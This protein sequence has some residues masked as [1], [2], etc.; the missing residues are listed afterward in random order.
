LTPCKAIEHQICLLDT[1]YIDLYLIHAP[2]GHKP[3]S[4]KFD[5]ESETDE[6]GN[7]ILDDFD[8]VEIWRELENAVDL[9]LVKH[10][11]VSNFDSAQVDNILKN[12]RIR[13]INNQIEI[14]PFL[15]QSEIMRH[16]VN[17]NISITSYMSL[18]RGDR[19]KVKYPTG[20]S[21]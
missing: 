1:D 4:S 7:P 10:I 8:H 5:L 14:H 9:G 21:L 3:K 16:H 18:G 17:E 13:P 19:T 20:E 15:D 6:S 2:W 11:G 12:C